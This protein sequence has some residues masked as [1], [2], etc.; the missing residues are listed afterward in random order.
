VREEKREQ[1]ADE[2]RNKKEIETRRTGSVQK[3]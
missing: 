2:T 1:E 3:Q